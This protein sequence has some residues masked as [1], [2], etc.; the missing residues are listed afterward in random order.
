MSSLPAGTEKTD[1][2]Y[3]DDTVRAERI[4]SFSCPSPDG[5][6]YDQEEDELVLVTQGRAV[7]EFENGTQTLAPGDHT[8]IPAHARHRVAWTSEECVWICIFTRIKLQE[9]AK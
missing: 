3:K 4:V 2:I 9:A 8:V 1:I 6:W 5:F 7:L